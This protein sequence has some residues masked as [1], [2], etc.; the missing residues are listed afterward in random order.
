MNMRL[1]HLKAYRVYTICGFMFLFAYLFSFLLKGQVL[2]ELAAYYGTEAKNYITGAV[3][4]HFVGLWTGGYAAKD[5]ASARK[6]LIL[7]MGLCV[8]F[9]VPFYFRSSP[10]WEFGLIIAGYASGCGLAALGYL[11]KTF[12][13]KGERLRACTDGLIFSKILAVGIEILSVWASPFVAL[14]ILLI[15]L[16]VGCFLISLLPIVSEPEVSF[17]PQRETMFQKDYPLWALVL[18]V[19]IV[20]GASGLMQQVIASAFSS[21]R[22]LAGWYW[23][24]P[25]V[26]TLAIVRGSVWFQKNRSFVLYIG[27]TMML[28]AMLAFV[29]L[30]RG[31]TDYLLINTFIFTAYGI[32][33]IYLW[34]IL[35]DMVDYTAN[36]A[37]FLGIG[38]SAYVLGA[39]CG[40]AL[41]LSIADAPLLAAENAVIVLSVIGVTLMLMPP[42]NRRLTTALKD[43]A[44]PP[45][46]CDSQEQQHVLALDRVRQA[47]LFCQIRN[48]ELL[49]AR[50]QEVLHLLLLGKSNREIAGDL[51][52]S[53]NTVKTHIRNI[54]AKY[55]VSSRTEL[56]SI[57]LRSPTDD[58]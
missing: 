54:F 57:L 20:V 38:L 36:P 55:K 11:L 39:F 25:Y 9:S 24:A 33:D 50:E 47:D 26:L 28:A 45:V 2:Q 8:L 10:L 17:S 4:A 51:Y 29:F 44:D 23:A 19:F 46:C 56:V 53:E 21:V 15:C 40:G 43:Y 18:F 13:S 31:E 14:S 32:F 34:S 3:T 1:H 48:N 35:A 37:K 27:M 52:I 22:S 16:L 58:E 41:G 42:L 6:V 7:A 12:T 30:G 49:T 5:T